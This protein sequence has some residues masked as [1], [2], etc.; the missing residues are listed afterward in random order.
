[1]FAFLDFFSLHVK[2]LISPQEWLKEI[3]NIILFNEN[4]AF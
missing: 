2:G 1:M 3:I 4:E